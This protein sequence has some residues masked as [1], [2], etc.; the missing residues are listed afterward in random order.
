MS[1]IAQYKAQ[2]L[3]TVNSN[4]G[5][6]SG[7][8]WYDAGTQAKAA[9]DISSVPDGLF[10]NWVFTGWSG[11]ATGAGLQSNAI[12]MDAPKTVTATWVINIQ[13]HSTPSLQELLSQSQS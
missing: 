1:L 11:D 13:Q 5:S 3:L 9:I 12:T 6:P 4:Y 2:Y 8:G 7:G 10:Y